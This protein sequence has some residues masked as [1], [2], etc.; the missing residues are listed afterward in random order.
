MGRQ[1]IAVDCDDVIANVNDSVREYI[2]ETRG[3]SHSADEYRVPGEYKRYWERIWNIPEN[4]SVNW[5]SE[6]IESG[7]M[8][9]LDPIQGALDALRSLRRRYSLVL[10][11]ARSLREVDYTEHWLE[12]H[13]PGVFD[14][15]TFVH[16]WSGEDGALASKASICTEL[17]ADYLIDDNYDHCQLMAECGRT[18]LLFGEYGWNVSQPV[19]SGMHRARDWRA[20][21][22][23]FT[24]ER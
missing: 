5:L 23:Y 7:R 21:E 3:F 2:N 8:Y 24:N 14:E 15:V 4:Q 22:E 20:V 10:V 19:V 1:R 12:R 6:Y 9:D 16:R 11:T 13:A 17:G 18:A